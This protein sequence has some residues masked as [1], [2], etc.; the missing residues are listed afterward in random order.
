MGKSNLGEVFGVND[1]STNAPSLRNPY[2]K[3]KEGDFPIPVIQGI[4]DMQKRGAMFC[5]CHLAMA[6]YSGAIAEKMVLD[7]K[8]VY[9][10]WVDAVEPGIQIV[11]S[12]VWALG[13]AQENGCGYV[14][15]SN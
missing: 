7:P 11:P 5:V 2:Y 15:A 6:V 3:P 10:E 8:I 12:G 14:F 1:K 13:R 4:K 9:Q